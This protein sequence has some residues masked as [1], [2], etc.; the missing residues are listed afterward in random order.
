MAFNDLAKKKGVRIVAPDRYVRSLRC[1]LGNTLLTEDRPGMGGST[2]VPLAIRMETWLGIVPALLAHLHLEHVHLMAH[3]AG[4]MYLLN[5]LHD[6]R[7]SLLGGK[8]TYIGIMGPW[9]HDEHS[10]VA[11]LNWAAKLPNGLLDSWNGLIKTINTSIAPSVAWSGGAISALAGTFQSAPSKDAGDEDASAKLYGTSKEVAKEIE[12]LQFKFFFAEDTTAGNE[13][14][15]MGLKMGG[16][17]LW[18]ACEDYA[19]FVRTLVKEEEKLKDADPSNAGLKIRV[20]YAES[21]MMIGK[22]GQKYFEECWSQDGV[23]GP[24]DYE[25]RE[26]PGTNH[27]TVFINA[28]KSAL[29]IIFEDIASLP[30]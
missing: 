29:P 11:I 14:A 21:D 5:T 30:R 18:G 9:V 10:H 26:M 7:G 22:G 6:Q 27:E 15:R 8:E 24:I 16:N 20:F 19:E 1:Q 12:R 13:D 28:D 17:D 23:P 4:T 25:G 2:Q 3:S